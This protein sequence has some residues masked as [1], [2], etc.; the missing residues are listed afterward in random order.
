MFKY[1]LHFLFPQWYYIGSTK[2][3][4]VDNNDKLT[5]CYD[6]S[7]FIEKTTNKRKIKYHAS[8]PKSLYYDDTELKAHGEYGRIIYPFLNRL[9]A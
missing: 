7:F 4:Y 2:Y 6:I 5:C 8:G 3:T 9:N 1:F